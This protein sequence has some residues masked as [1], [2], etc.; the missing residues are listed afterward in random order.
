MKN[1]FL[2]IKAVFASSVTARKNRKNQLTKG[3]RIPQL[4]CALLITVVFSVNFYFNIV[5]YA[6]LSLSVNE[7]SNYFIPAISF[8]ILYSFF[9]S[10]TLSFNVFFLSN[11][12]AFLSLPISG[13]RLLSARF[14]LH[15]FNSFCYGSALILVEL[16]M[17]PII[18]I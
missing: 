2:L 5:Q 17:I 8:S 16:L 7:I 10:L 3:S 11:N 1:Y 4:L 13:N 18:L 15:F 9:F 12:E 6:S 14:F